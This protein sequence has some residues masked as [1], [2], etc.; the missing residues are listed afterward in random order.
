[1]Y[2]IKNAKKYKIYEKEPLQTQIYTIW[3][4]TTFEGGGK[5]RINYLKTIARENEK[6]NPNI[7]YL[8]KEIQPEK[9][10]DEL[11]TSTPDM[12]SFGY[13][14][15]EILLQHL[16]E[17]DETF[18]VRNDLVESAKF[19]NKIYAIPYILSGYAMITHNSQ[20]TEFHVGTNDYVNPSIIY[21]ELNL[22]PAQAETQYDAY[23]HFV[24]SKKA[25]LLGT[26]RDVFRVSN[27]NSIGRTNAI[28]SPV[29]SYTDLIQY[30]GLL[31]K[32][33][34]TTKF[35]K[36][37]VQNEN[38]KKL[39][40][41]SLF[42]TTDVELYNDGIYKDMEIALKT[43]RKGNVFKKWKIWVYKKRKTKKFLHF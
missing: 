21:N 15:G 18:L 9:L 23:R 28:I 6:Q 4:V 40:D 14:V 31:K 13:G 35:L 25:V 38:Q 7:L 29:G 2:A 42:S 19:N 12:I 8:I 22:T 37:V 41:F 1:M 10:E 17:I 16:E 24:Y 5:D 43:A 26:A 33:N 20:N 11:S 36:Q 3:H 27:L 34:V 30:F 32:D 39:K